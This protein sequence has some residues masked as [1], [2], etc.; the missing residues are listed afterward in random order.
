MSAAFEVPA[1]AA[2]DAPAGVSGAAGWAFFGPLG[3]EQ[4]MIPDE[5]DARWRAAYAVYTQAAAGVG[6]GEGYAPEAARVMAS[7]S[8]EAAQLW[9]EIAATPGLPWWALA[10]VRSTAE[11]FEAQAHDWNGKAEIALPRR[12][13]RTVS[14]RRRDRDGG[15]R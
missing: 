7:A 5:L 13:V 14:A 2:L 9:R 1:G 10:S 12:G 8:W 11:A 4:V 6:D 3:E 15:A